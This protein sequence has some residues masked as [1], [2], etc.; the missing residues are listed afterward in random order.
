MADYL[1]YT[2]IY[3]DTT[4]VSGV[5]GDNASNKS[6]YE[7]NY[8][9]STGKVDEVTLAATTFVFEQDYDDFKTLVTDPIEWADVKELIRGNRYLL[10]IIS[11]TEL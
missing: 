4:N 8:Q 5:P 3:I 9:S 10:Y 6:D 11:N 7:T 1:Y 2:P